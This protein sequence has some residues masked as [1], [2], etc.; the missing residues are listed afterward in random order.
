VD[1]NRMI[2]FMGGAWTSKSATVLKYVHCSSTVTE[3]NRFIWKN[4]LMRFMF[5][6]VFGKI[7]YGSVL[8]DGA[9]VCGAKKW[10]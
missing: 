10:V 2:L 4:K 5:V 3:S 7:S 8:V 9:R 1:G 6:V